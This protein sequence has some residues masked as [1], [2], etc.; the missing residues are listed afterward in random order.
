LIF[1]QNIC[2]L[3]RLENFEKFHCVGGAAAAFISYRPP[4]LG[5]FQNL[6]HLGGDGGGSADRLTPLPTNDRKTDRIGSMSV[7]SSH[8][9]TNILRFSVLEIIATHNKKFLCVRG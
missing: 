4:W 5:N 2:R 9:S 7:F 1:V 8:V 6:R 3:R